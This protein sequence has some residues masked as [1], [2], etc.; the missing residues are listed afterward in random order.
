MPSTM[1]VKSLLVK[2]KFL[3]TEFFFFAKTSS[4][5]LKTQTKQ[6]ILGGGGG[7]VFSPSKFFF[8]KNVPGVLK[9]M[10]TFFFV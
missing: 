5:G 3:V 7:G 4:W 8:F 6:K 10:H 1:S 9:R 2:M